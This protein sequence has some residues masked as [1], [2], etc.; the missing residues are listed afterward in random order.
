M[1]LKRD[2]HG[3]FIID[4]SLVAEKFQIGQEQFRRHMMIGLVTSVVE[5]GVGSDLGRQRL[6]VRY[7]N[8]VWRAILDDDHV[9]LTDEMLKVG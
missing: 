1:K 7:G 6:S 3:D 5:K 2:D 8:R 9:V 4:A